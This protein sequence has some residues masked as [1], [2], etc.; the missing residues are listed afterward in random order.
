MKASRDRWITSRS[1]VRYI[2]MRLRVSEGQAQKILS[3]AYQSGAVRKARKVG[4][5]DEDDP[6]YT[7]SEI[8]GADLKPWL[9][10]HSE[11]K[12]AA[13]K[14]KKAGVLSKAKRS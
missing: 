3:E 2:R 1:A 13:L 7:R 4:G 5:V 12:S 6:N 8:S 9:D 11:P 10:E 14:S